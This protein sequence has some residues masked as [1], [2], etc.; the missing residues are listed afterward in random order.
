MISPDNDYNRDE[1]YNGQITGLSLNSKKFAPSEFKKICRNLINSN[2]QEGFLNL[3]NYQIFN[4][5]A[6]LYSFT[7]APTFREKLSIYREIRAKAKNASELYIGTLVQPDPDVQDRLA[8]GKNSQGDTQSV[9]FNP[10]SFSTAALGEI[11]T[12]QATST[13]PC[14]ISDSQTGETLVSRKRL[15]Q[16]RSAYRRKKKLPPSIENIQ[17]A[18][19][20]TLKRETKPARKK[21][22]THL[23]TADINIAAKFIN[24]RQHR[25]HLEYLDEIDGVKEKIT[26][27][28]IK[29]G[30]DEKTAQALIAQ[31]A[32]YR[33]RCIT[34]IRK[35]GTRVTNTVYPSSM[36]QTKN[37][38]NHNAINAMLERDHEE[39]VL[40]ITIEQKQILTDIEQRAD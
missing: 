2:T 5:S 26:R 18:E 15:N 17:S 4:L 36:L 3:G 31:Q 28:V 32:N 14:I 39:Q 21:D 37:G 27:V 24:D 29:G 8:V 19:S 10:K 23:G 30:L 1:Y 9:T 20:I 16:L 13:N 6:A 34:I 12:Y 25:R 33:D 7:K 35:Q 11:I 38:L 22:H 40:S